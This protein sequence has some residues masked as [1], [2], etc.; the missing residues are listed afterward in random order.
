MD[1][2]SYLRDGRNPDR[3]PRSLSVVIPALNEVQN[4]PAVIKSIPVTELDRAQWD[5]EVIIVDNGSTDGTGDM[6]AAHGAKVVV[7]PV[8][9][10]GSA[11]KAGFAASSGAVIAT[12]DADCTYPFDALCGL[13][14]RLHFDRLD[15]LST[16]RL[17]TANSAA[18]KRSHLVGNR[19]LTTAS[20]SLFRSPF[21]DSQSGMWVF[22]REIWA[23]L[24][25]RSQG[26]AFSQEIKHEAYLKGYRCAE[27]PIEYRMR[28]G[29]V[30][31]NA[32]RDGLLN[33]SQLISHR[34]RARRN[35]RGVVCA[36]NNDAWQ[37]APTLS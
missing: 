17:G 29:K 14:E 35:W 27:V 20:R 1:P 22:R 4:I 34:I 19:L 6:A 36:A 32:G 37:G 31:L 21:H 26:M 18:L 33:A 9:G 7:E 15:F 12:G 30:K 10:Y 8:R 11:Y 16:Y 3:G 5:V 2:I 23:Y 25:V 24:D 13:L 28:R